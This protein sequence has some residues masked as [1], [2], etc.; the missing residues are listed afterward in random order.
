MSGCGSAW[1]RLRPGGGSRGVCSTGEISGE[2][3][4]CNTGGNAGAP[5][6]KRRLA[7]NGLLFDRRGASLLPPTV[8]GAGAVR[9][10]PNI[11]F[12]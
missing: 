3:A 4:F 12:L 7:L 5:K 10:E 11:L 9:A 2:V 1:S 8:C 6:K